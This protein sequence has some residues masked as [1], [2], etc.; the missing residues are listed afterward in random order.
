[1]YVAAHLLLCKPLLHPGHKSLVFTGHGV[2]LVIEFTHLSLHGHLPRA[3]LLQQ[4]QLCLE[5]CNLRGEE[6]EEEEEEEGG[7]GKG[8]EEEEEGRD[9]FE[10]ALFRL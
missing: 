10:R 1:M 5:C 7:G 9:T 2:H 4:L 6:W 3:E 8:E